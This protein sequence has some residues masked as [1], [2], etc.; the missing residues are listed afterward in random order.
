MGEQLITLQG[1]TSFVYS[2]A[3]IP[4]NSATTGPELASVGEDRTL[5]IWSGTFEPLVFYVKQ[6]DFNAFSPEIGQN[7]QTIT[8]PATSVWTVAATSDGDLVTG[9]SDGIIRVWTRNEDR[10]ASE[11]ELK[12]YDAEVS[13]QQIDQCVVLGHGAK[14]LAPAA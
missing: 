9:S 2:L 13:K 3:I 14:F 7:V 6:A 10:V 1:H 5:R 8:L 11:E 4:S 12:T